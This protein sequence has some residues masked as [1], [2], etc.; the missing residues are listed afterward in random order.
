MNT[1]AKGTK[2]EREIVNLF[3]ET[4]KWGCVRVAGSGSTHFPSADILASNRERVVAIECKITKENNKYFPKK[5]IAQLKN[6]A[7]YFGAE[8]WVSVKFGT[9]E[10]FFLVPEDMEETKQ[11]YSI[12]KKTAETKGLLFKE[13]LG[14]G[15]D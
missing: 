15:F 10:W 14:E 2:G 6:F 4:G 11:G 5:E 1:K 3:W 7:F 9:S 13:F 12:N 8:P